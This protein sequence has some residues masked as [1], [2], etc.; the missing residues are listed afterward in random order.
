MSSKISRYTASG[1]VEITDLDSLD[2]RLD[3]IEA[4]M[5]GSIYTVG[6]AEMGSRDAPWPTY[7]RFGHASETANVNGW[8][9][10]PDSTLEANTPLG[11]AMYVIEQGGSELARFSKARSQVNGMGIGFSP[12]Y[13]PGYVSLWRN[14][15]E[16]AGNYVFLANTTDTFI[17]CP[18]GGTL[19]MRRNN[20]DLLTLGTDNILSN[21]GVVRAAGNTDIGNNSIYFVSYG[22]G[23]YMTDGTWVRSTNDKNV[24]LGGGWYGTNGGITIGRGGAVDGSY[25]CDV[26]G[27]IRLDGT[28]YCGDNVYAT[29]QVRS[30]W[31]DYASD[32]WNYAHLLGYPTINNG[33][34]SRLALHSPGVAPQLRATGSQGERLVVINN[35]SSD[36]APIAAAAH[37]NISTIRIKKD[38][39]SLRERDFLPVHLDPFVDTVDDLP[40][41]MSLNPVVF[42]RKTGDLQIVPTDSRGDYATV[43]IDDPTTFESIERTDLMGQESRRERLGLI[44]EEVQ[45]V[46]PSAVNHDID[47]AALAIDYAQV[48]VALLDHVQRLTEEVATLRYRIAE[49]ERE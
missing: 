7:A 36:Y 27:N 22:G 6:V 8:L 41:I 17:N 25:K 18:N 12:P 37:E 38:V 23:W 31:N 21:V 45:H 16:A 46:I 19:H 49:L 5:A 32:A 20:T 4:R 47:A 40:D 44:A 14:G 9:V 10:Q 3:T 48:T 39:R 24:W 35:Q 28:L 43:D 1:W 2:A 30:T 13:G 33:Q 29:R 42:R 15:D 34:Q 26:A 11:K